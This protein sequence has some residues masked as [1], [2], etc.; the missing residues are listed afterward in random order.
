M[1]G[2][3]NNLRARMEEA[4]LSA[5]EL[6]KR[7]GLGDSAVSE[8]LRGKSK[9]PRHGTLERLAG[10][11]SCSVADLAGGRVIAVTDNKGVPGNTTNTPIFIPATNTMPVDLPIYG[12]AAGSEYGAFQMFN[13]V[14]DYVRRPPG[15]PTATN[16]YGLY[17]VG[18]CM[19][20]RY[21]NG[22]LVIIHPGR[23]V[24]PGDYV[25]VQ[26]KKDGERAAGIKRLKRRTAL[27]V[28]LEQ[29]NPLAEITIEAADIISIHRILTPA[30]LFGLA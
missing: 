5:K 8:I 26:F 30:E 22:D 13:D 29:I 1:V 4:G 28:V 23:P 6:S 24:R 7:A 17:V 14:V 11:L 9:D 25:V 2:L 19:S 18:D 12:T 16:A 10:V 21:D 3:I 15:V 20:P 27:R